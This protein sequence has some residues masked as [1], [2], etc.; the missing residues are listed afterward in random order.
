MLQQIRINRAEENFTGFGRVQERVNDPKRIRDDVNRLVAARYFILAMGIALIAW[1]GVRLLVLNVDLTS[2]QVLRA[3]MVAVIGPGLAWAA[4]D[5]E[6]GLLRVV[7]GRNQEIAQ[8][9]RENLALNKMTQDHLAECLATATPGPRVHVG[10]HV[11]R[12]P[13]PKMLP[14]R[15]STLDNHF[16][17]KLR[18]DADK[19]IVLDPDDNEI[20]YRYFEAAK[21]DRIKVMA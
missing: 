18:P 16:G 21:N 11:E 3:V 13:A 15:P 12:S 10:T 5:K 9:E 2:L 19:V 14:D 8:R 7:D 6:L 1:L 20:D 4:S 17:T